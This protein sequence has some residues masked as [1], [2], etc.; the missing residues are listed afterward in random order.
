MKNRGKIVS[1]KAVVSSKGQVI[2]PQ[3]VRDCLGISAGQEL[4]FEVNKK[5]VLE[6]RQIKSINDFIVCCK[7]SISDHGRHF[8]KDDD[9]IA[10]AV[11]SNDKRSER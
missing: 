3:I 4:L 11:S 5:G 1:A 7:H 2:I 10:K 8:L 9:A 6:V